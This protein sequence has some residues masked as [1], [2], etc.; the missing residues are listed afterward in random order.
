MTASQRRDHLRAS[1]GLTSLSLTLEVSEM[2][3]IQELRSLSE[4]DRVHAVDEPIAD[5]CHEIMVAV[6]FAAAAD[7]TSAVDWAVDDYVIKHV[8]VDD[9]DR[10]SGVRC[11]GFGEELGER[12]FD[13]DNIEG[14]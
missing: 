9:E 10:E 2:N 14:A 7:R 3:F 1:L 5:S 13:V 12:L 4:G 11:S 8:E 6:E